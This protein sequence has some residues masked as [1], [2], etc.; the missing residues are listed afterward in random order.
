MEHAKK[1]LLQ[2]LL[3][4][5]CKKM[6]I[7]IALHLNAFEIQEM[8]LNIGDFNKYAKLFE[9]SM[10]KSICNKDASW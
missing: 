7:C 9:I 6:I 4:N 8:L 10:K 1:N 2:W 5:W 3:C